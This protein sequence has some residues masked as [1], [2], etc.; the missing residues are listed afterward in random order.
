MLE[1]YV[2]NEQVSSAGLCLIVLL[3]Y[4]FKKNGAKTVMFFW[5]NL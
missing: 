1:L 4:C 5:M 3:S 2:F